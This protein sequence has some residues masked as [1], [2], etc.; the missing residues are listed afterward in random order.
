MSIP[1]FGNSGKTF[2][3]LNSNENQSADAGFGFKLT[4]GPA[5]KPSLAIRLALLVA[6]LI[7]I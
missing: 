5:S 7:L 4:A 2:G 3:S 1:I 6:V